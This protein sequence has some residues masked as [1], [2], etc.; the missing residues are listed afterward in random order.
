MVDPGSNLSSKV[1]FDGGTAYLASGVNHIQRGTVTDSARSSSNAELLPHACTR[2]HRF[3]PTERH[4]RQLL[5]HQQSQVRRHT[6]PEPAIFCSPP[7]TFRC[8]CTRWPST[9]RVSAPVGQWQSFARHRVRRRCVRCYHSQRQ[10]F[11]R[12]SLLSRYRSAAI[13]EVGE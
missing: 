9:S 6:C 4:S 10:Q 1:P 3:T 13:S 2:I 11:G 8:M 5:H 7:G 12:G